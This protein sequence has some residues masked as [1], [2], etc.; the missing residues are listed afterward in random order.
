MCNAYACKAAC[1]SAEDSYVYFILVSGHRHK[2][3]SF[4]GQWSRKSLG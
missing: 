3:T 4:N 2:N 1:G